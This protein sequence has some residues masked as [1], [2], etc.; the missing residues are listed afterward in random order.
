MKSEQYE[1]PFVKPK[2][3]SKPKIKIKIRMGKFL[4]II[5]KFD[6]NKIT[7]PY[8]DHARDAIDPFCSAIKN[9]LASEDNNDYDY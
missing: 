8:G 4:P 5:T 1:F 6:V 3:I 7:G 9:E 2:P